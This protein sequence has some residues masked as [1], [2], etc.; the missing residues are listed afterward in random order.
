MR[1]ELGAVVGA[2]ENPHF[3]C[4]RPGGFGAHG[5]E[6]V[7]LRERPPGGPGVEV[8]HLGGEILRSACRVG[9]QG[10]GGAAIRTGGAAHAEVDPPWCDG[11]QHAELFGDFERRVVRQH[12]AGTAHPYTRR[13]GGNGGGQ[14]FRSGARHRLGAVVLGEPV[15]VVAVGF[16]GFRQL[17]GFADGDI[18]AE[19]AAGR[20]LVED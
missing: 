15:A 6:G 12:D 17:Q 10:E 7:V 20:G 16:A 13:G 11:L 14:N 1:R 9:V 3:G 18:R 2:A 19:A 4:M 8:T 5:A